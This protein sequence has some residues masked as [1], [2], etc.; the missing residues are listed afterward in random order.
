MEL[1]PEDVAK[2]QHRAWLNH[3]ST[4]QMFELLELKKESSMNFSA[5]RAYSTDTPDA[6]FRM[7]AAEV[8]FINTIVTIIK[9]SNAFIETL[10][11]KQSRK[12]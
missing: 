12:K 2:E 5:V 8:L 6:M 1:N 3:P 10:K 9:D 7:Y 4:I 11:N